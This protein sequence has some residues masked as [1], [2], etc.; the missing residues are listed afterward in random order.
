MTT[1]QA[2][3]TLINRGKLATCINSA[4]EQHL[5]DLATTL[6][7][8]IAFLGLALKEIDPDRPLPP[9]VLKFLESMTQE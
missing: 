9:T 5:F 8:M 7:K 3:K 2:I 4:H 1:A 6:E